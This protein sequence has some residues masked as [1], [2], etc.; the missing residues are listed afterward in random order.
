MCSSSQIENLKR[1]LDLFGCCV[2]SRGKSGG[3]ALLWQKSVE[4]QL[5]S[6][7]KY[8]V[9]ASVRTEESDECWRFTGVYGEPDASKWS[10]FWHILCRLSQQSVRP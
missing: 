2:E 1:K 7:S 6:F 10:E 4:V 8:H 9:D 3:L 5:Q